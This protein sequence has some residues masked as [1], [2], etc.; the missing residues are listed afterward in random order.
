MRIFSSVAFFLVVFCAT[1]ITL[2]CLSYNYGIGAVSDKSENIEF[3]VEP[4]STYLSVADDLKEKNLIRS[5][6]F[7]KIYIKIFKPTNLQAG[8]YLLTESMGVKKIIETL[9]KGTNSNPDAV[10]VTIPEGRQIEYAAELFAE[11]TNNTKE[12]L[13]ALWNSN[14][15][16]NKVIAKYDFVTDEVKDNKIKIGLEGYFFPSTYQLQN[17]DVDG[18]YI[19]FKMLDQMD[20]VLKKYSNE[21]KNSKYSVH[22]LL[23]MAS[24]VEYEAIEDIDRPM[25]AGVF[26][27]RLNKPQRLES[28]ATLGYALGYHKKIY[29]RAE[30]KF[31]SPYNTY[32]TDGLPPGPGNLP[33]EKSIEAAI[34][35]TASD[36]YY[37][38]ADV[39]HDGYGENNKVYYSKDYPQHLNY[40]KQYLNCQ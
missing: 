17:V 18:E 39:C 1:V 22:E 40:K 35:P 3:S 6:V 29:T 37:F 16:I 8:T 19:A 27:N 23:T 25:I 28:C 21:I 10:T 4:G 26:Y 38:L 7:Y 31:A 34:K 30:T 20:K 11:K 36:Y 12:S 33:G 15:F 24:I 14:E 13:L 32:Y 2:G 5:A 9:E